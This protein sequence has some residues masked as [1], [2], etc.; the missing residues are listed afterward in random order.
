MTLLEAALG[1]AAQGLRVHPCRPADKKPYTRW[2]RTATTIEADVRKLWYA[3]PDA[4][5]AV[6]TGDGLV[7][8]DD[9]R[10][11][12]EPDPAMATTLTCRTRSRGW[13]HWFRTSNPIGC[14]V[15]VIPGLDIRG[16]GGYV[17]APPSEGW[18]WFND[19]P[20]LPL[21]AEIVAVW[22]DRERL[23]RFGPGFK[24]AERVAEGGR[25][26]YM[27]QFVGYAI[28]MGFDTL[29][30]LLPLALEHNAEVCVPPLDDAEVRRTTRSI[31]T[32]HERA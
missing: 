27:A 21:P 24:M 3:W 25:N 18:E 8:V 9:D 29:D 12:A 1:Y 15:G 17:I 14:A 6:C 31:L 22:K 28:R 4:L 7:V 32:R 11:L 26:S 16:N 5:I 23:S 20:M 2:S 10:G 19:A 30:E 13:H